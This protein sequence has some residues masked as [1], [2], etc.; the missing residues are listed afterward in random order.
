[1]MQV[2]TEHEQRTPPRALA[3]ILVPLDSSVC[4]VAA[5]DQ[6]AELADRFGAAIDLLHV[7]QPPIHGGFVHATCPWAQTPAALNKQAWQEES[8]TLDAMRRRI[9]NKGIRDPG[10]RMVTGSPVAAII[11]AAESGGYDLVVMGTHGRRGLSRLLAGSVAE[12]VVRRCTVPVMTV[13]AKE[14]S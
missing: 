10:R 11:E 3:K 9:R 8:R 2:V 12:A 6:A 7:W 4:S 13:H 1:M 14:P 5:L